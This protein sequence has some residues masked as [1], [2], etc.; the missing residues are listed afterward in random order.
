MREPARDRLVESR[1]TTIFA[2]SVGM[3]ISD[4]HPIGTRWIG[5]DGWLH[6]RRG[7]WAA[8]DP[9]WL[10]DGFDPGPWRLDPP[11]HHMRNFLDCLASRK[12]CHAP[13]ETA[14][15]SITPGHLAYVSWKLK[16]P[17]QWNAAD[18]T[19]VGDDEANRL[20]YHIDYR[21][22]WSFAE[23]ESAD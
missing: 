6:V 23:V 15:R 16:R 2:N 13:P 3:T 9:S 1:S 17:L 22:P 7:K 5:E 10:E 4:S 18:E 20:L 12:P 11:I 14:H 19:I 8:S 21:S